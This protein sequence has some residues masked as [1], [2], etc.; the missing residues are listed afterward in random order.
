MFNIFWRRFRNIWINRTDRFWK[1]CCHGPRTYRRISE[2]QSRTAYSKPRKRLLAVKVLAIQR[3]RFRRTCV[4]TWLSFDF[5]DQPPINIWSKKFS[6][7]FRL[8]YLD[9]LDVG[10]IISGT[11]IHHKVRAIGHLHRLRRKCQKEKGKKEKIDIKKT[12][13][14]FS[15][16]SE[17]Q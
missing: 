9:F 14:I 5:I 12:L 17:N 16:H 11:E 3:L 10:S 7:L 15:F 1:I 4:A 2:S 8:K 13:P 6:Q